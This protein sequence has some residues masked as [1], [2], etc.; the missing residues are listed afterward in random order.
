MNQESTPDDDND[1]VEESILSF[2]FMDNVN[3]SHAEFFE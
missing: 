3:E 1:F 2:N